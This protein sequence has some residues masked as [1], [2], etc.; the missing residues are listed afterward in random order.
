MR[1]MIIVVAKKT[2]KHSGPK[3]KNGGIMSGHDYHTSK[4]LGELLEISK[5]GQFAKMELNTMEQSEVLLTNLQKKI[6]YRL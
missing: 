2:S 1:G 3:L 6:I 4:K 5:T